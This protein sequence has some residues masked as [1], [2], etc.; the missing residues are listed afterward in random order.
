MRLEDVEPSYRNAVEKKLK[1][2]GH[3]G[4]D[5]Q[6][7]LRNAL[8]I[9]DSLNEQDKKYNAKEDAFRKRKKPVRLGYRKGTKGN[10]DSKDDGASA[11]ISA[12]G[13]PLT[14]GDGAGSEGT[15]E[16]V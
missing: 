16:G 2:Q 4:N 9:P 7:A 11:H 14:G 1:A 15:A 13:V 3:E 10:S 6:R 12:N 5:L 8:G